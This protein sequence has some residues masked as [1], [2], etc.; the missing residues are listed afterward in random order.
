MQTFV[1]IEEVAYTMT[2]TMPFNKMCER[3]IANLHG[4]E[5]SPVI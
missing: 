1:Y 3:V 2:G 4:N 5:S